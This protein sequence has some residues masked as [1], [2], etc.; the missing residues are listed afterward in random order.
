M[1]SDNSIKFPSLPGYDGE[2]AP[3][4]FEPIL[5]SGERIT[6]AIAVL[7]E[8]REFK[9]FDTLSNEVIDALYGSKSEQV[10]NIVRWCRSSLEQHISVNRSL[11]GWKSPING[12]FMGRV[13]QACDSDI[14]KIARQA[15]QFSSS[16]SSLSMAAERDYED[17]KE[18]NKQSERW[19][20]SIIR[21]VLTINP[22]Y[23]KCFKV[24]V[25]LGNSNV[26][27]QFGFLTASTAINFAIV[28]PVRSAASLNNIKARILDLDYLKNS[29][30]LFSPDNFA[31]IIGVPKKDDV[32]IE[33]KT[34]IKI[35]DILDSIYEIGDKENIIVHTAEDS[36][37]A[38]VKLIDI[39][40]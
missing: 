21:E 14:Y 17:F 8:G 2:W 3:I 1:L 40:A 34:K 39:A 16:L 10:I 15:I 23:K 6:I 37:S 36:Y 31:L 38:A 22:N 26:K 20:E 35:S 11:L 33:K 28:S 27:T 7:G 9:V 18:S 25:E 12:V 13:T 19:Q 32:T 4:F 29:D 5:A 30:L 24:K